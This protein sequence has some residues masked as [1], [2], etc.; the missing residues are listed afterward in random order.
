MGGDEVMH[1]QR[2]ACQLGVFNKAPGT[3]LCETDANL[4]P[5]QAIGA[6][7]YEYIDWQY[8]LSDPESIYAN[9]L[10]EAHFAQPSV[11]FVRDEV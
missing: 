10:W 3:S 5:S 9:F 1:P 2:L 7:M 11:M 8:G 6:G 4:F